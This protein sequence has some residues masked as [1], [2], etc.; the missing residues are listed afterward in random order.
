MKVTV[1]PL[2]SREVD[3]FFPVFAQ[4]LQTEFPQ[5]TKNVVRYFLEK[6]YSRINFIYWL[7]NRLKTIFIARDETGKIIGFAIVDEPYGG[8]SLCRWLGVLREHQRKG[9]GRA[10]MEAWTK[11]AVSQGCHKVEL[12]AQPDAKVFYE[13]IGLELEGYRKLSYFGCDQYSFGKVIGKAKDEVM[14][15]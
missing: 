13:K 7:D 12:A 9:A 11:L 6:I 5:Y 4:V 2:P 14:A 8:V 10:L 1:S 3:L 15:P